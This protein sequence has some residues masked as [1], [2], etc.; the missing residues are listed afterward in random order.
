MQYLVPKFIEHKPKIVGPLTFGQIIFIGVAVGVCVVFYFILA[1][2]SFSLYIIFCSILGGIGFALAFLKIEGRPLPVILS[3]FFKFF[4]SPKLYLWRKK[5]APPPKI[6]SKKEKLKKSEELIKK[7]S[8]PKIATRSK[9]KR[10][11][12]EIETK[13][14]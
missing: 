9:L 13:I 5:E 3:H 4:I 2:I 10:L 6:I 1:K 7:V 12:T 11:S 14:R 8:P